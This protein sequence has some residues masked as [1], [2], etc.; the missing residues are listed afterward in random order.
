[1]GYRTYT[2]SVHR[3]CGGCSLLTRPYPLQLAR[4]QEEVVELFSGFPE[5]RIEPIIGMEEPLHFRNKILT[6][7]ASGKK[8]RHELDRPKR[9]TSAGNKK[10]RHEL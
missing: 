2:C 6:P 9:I 8:G 3:D 10:G 4:K 1:M 5:A 7:F